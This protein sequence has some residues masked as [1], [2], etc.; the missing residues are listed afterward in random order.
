MAI[1]GQGDLD[2]YIPVEELGFNQYLQRLVKVW[3]QPDS[4]EDLH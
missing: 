3:G 1:S 2:V 4:I